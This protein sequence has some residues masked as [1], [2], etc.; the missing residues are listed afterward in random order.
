MYKK[1]FED[2]VWACYNFELIFIS[3]WNILKMKKNDLKQ[4]GL[5]NILV[6]VGWWDG[7]FDIQYHLLILFLKLLKQKTQ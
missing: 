4:G 5:N 6:K 7:T 3:I 1:Q 2:D